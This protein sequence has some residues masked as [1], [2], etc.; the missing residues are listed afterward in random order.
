MRKDR[1]EKRQKPKNLQ[2]HERRKLSRSRKVF[3]RLLRKR[4]TKKDQK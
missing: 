2:R 4:N 1:Q 3:D